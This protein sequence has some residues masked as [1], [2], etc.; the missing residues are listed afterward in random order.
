M[1]AVTFSFPPP[2]HLGGGLLSRPPGSVHLGSSF[3]QRDHL[4]FRGWNSQVTEIISMILAEL[5]VQQPYCVSL[6][7]VTAYMT[8]AQ[9]TPA[10]FG[11]QSALHISKKHVERFSLELPLGCFVSSFPSCSVPK[12]SESC[13]GIEG[14]GKK[15]C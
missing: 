11:A 4:W 2:P 5:L 13:M 8:L 10:S 6:P 9:H 14:E 15:K 7:T 1:Q 12:A 3:K